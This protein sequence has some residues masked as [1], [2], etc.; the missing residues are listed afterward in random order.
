[1]L[2]RLSDTE[3]GGYP[4]SSESPPHIVLEL[5]QVPGLVSAGDGCFGTLALVPSTNQT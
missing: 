5:R 1:M 3:N 4:A 2:A